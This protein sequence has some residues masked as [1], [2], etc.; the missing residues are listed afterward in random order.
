MND[1]E[2]LEKLRRLMPELMKTAGA[3]EGFLSAK[4]MKFLAMAAAC[5]TAEGVMLEI[6]SFKGKSTV[7]LATAGRL[8]PGAEVVAVD[9]LDY[10]PSF[11]PKRG[12]ES[13]LDDFNKNLREAKV[14][15]LV[16]LHQMR[17]QQLAPL[18]RR[19][20]KIRFLWIDGD[21]SYE[22]AKSDF[23]LFS[24]FLTDGAIVA[25]H[26]CFKHDVGPMRV[27]A[28]DMLLSK[29]FGAAGACGSIGWAQ[30]RA[31]PKKCEPF[32][33]A[34]LELYKRVAR[35]IPQAYLDPVEHGTGGAIYKFLRWR[36]P[37]DEIDPADW[38][39]Q[40]GLN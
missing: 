27:F 22:G 5:P 36:V 33:K 35:L 16:E 23:D 8:A 13:C 34:R 11:D 17:S 9:P 10:R 31:N 18:W 7:I 25:L 26:D 24:P 3:V 15:N 29:N 6:G 1:S 37:H 20:R 4:E 30:F 28:E 19:D 14:G 2:H 40:V 39:R 12:K 21:H 38:V 32:A